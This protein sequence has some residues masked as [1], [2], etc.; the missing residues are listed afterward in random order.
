MFI[1]SAFL[2]SGLIAC[3][4]FTVN[5]FAGEKVPDAMKIPVNGSTTPAATTDKQVAPSASADNTSRNK[6]HDGKSAVS[7]DQQSNDKSDV[8]ITRKIRQAVV[9][10]KSMSTSAQ[11]VKI[12]T[13]K[14]R[15]VLKGP[16]DS[17]E[18]KMKVEQAAAAV[19]GRDQIVSEIEVKK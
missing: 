16:V 12:I 6:V 8:E 13:A 2:A 19:A 9:K 1:R 4:L 11:N 10:D 18:E 17:N 5:A 7:A 14:G 3:N 15:V